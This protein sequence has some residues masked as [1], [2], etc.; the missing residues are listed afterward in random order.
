M[1]HYT[2]ILPNGMVHIPPGVLKDLGIRPGMPIQLHH[3][4]NNFLEL[5]PVQ[6]SDS[7]DRLFGLGKG[8]AVGI[9][10][11]DTSIMKAVVQDD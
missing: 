11:I 2:T 5:R 8:Y 1:D 9:V 7:I 4:S 3:S 6:K 10:D